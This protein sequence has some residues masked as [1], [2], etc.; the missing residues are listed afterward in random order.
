MENV[1]QQKNSVHGYGYGLTQ[2]ADH[3]H[4]HL[5]SCLAAKIARKAVEVAYHHRSEI[6]EKRDQKVLGDFTPYN[7]ENDWGYGQCFSVLNTGDLTETWSITIPSIRSVDDTCMLIDALM[8]AYYSMK[9]VFTAFQEQEEFKNSTS[10]RIVLDLPTEYPKAFLLQSKL[11]VDAT[12]MLSYLEKRD[13]L[14]VHE[15]LRSAQEKIIPYYVD[16]D[17]LGQ[18]IPAASFKLDKKKHVFSMKVMGEEFSS[19]MLKDKGSLF[20]PSSTVT[21]MQ[22]FICLV[23]LAALD[24]CLAEVMR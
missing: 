8:H 20:E 2:D 22:L 19:I 16:Q 3:I 9:A 12:K 1:S 14:F 18:S 11:S 5:S 21:T 24:E 4:I 10:Q 13:A 7:S 6:T 23:G 17:V 15:A